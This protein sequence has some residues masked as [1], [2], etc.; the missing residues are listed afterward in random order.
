MTGL[1]LIR[2]K[3]NALYKSAPDIHITAVLLNPKICFE[4][5]PAKITGVYPHIFRIE[6]HTGETP[7]SHT[8]QYTDILTNQVIIPELN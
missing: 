2:A 8:I 6:E 3:I 5:A 1:D 7:K 4:N